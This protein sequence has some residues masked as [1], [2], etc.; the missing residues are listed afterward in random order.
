[1]N[2][3]FW[4]RHGS[5]TC[6]ALLVHAA[7]SGCII[8]WMYSIQ[9]YYKSDK[10]LAINIICWQFCVKVHLTQRFVPIIRIIFLNGPPACGI[11]N[12]FAE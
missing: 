12:S 10:N 3:L 9:K 5:P 7:S 1:M 4:N 2:S 6:A 8:R 11:V